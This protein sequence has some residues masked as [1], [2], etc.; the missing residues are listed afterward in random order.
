[1]GGKQFVGTKR[2]ASI[3]SHLGL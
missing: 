1:L 2:F 3:A